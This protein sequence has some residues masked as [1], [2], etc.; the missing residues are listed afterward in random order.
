MEDDFIFCV[1]IDND[2]SVM[3]DSSCRFQRDVNIRI[4][5]LKISEL[6][7]M[8]IMVGVV[9]KDGICFG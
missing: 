4:F 3:I 9:A 1:I 8:E 5:S 7:C 6:S 2:L